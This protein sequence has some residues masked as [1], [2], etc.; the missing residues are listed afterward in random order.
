MMKTTKKESPG[1]IAPDDTIAQSTLKVALEQVSTKDRTHGDTEPSFRMI[2]EL[3][4]VYVFHTNTVRPEI[5]VS[6][7]DVAQMMVLLKVARSVYG[8]SADNYVDEG[9]YAALA[10]QFRMREPE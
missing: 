5:T 9:G 7:H 10:S 4:S 1:P 2:A 3:W 6:P 8:H